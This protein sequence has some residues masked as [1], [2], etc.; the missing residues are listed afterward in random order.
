MILI[1]GLLLRWWWM[2]RL[3]LYVIFGHGNIGD[4]LCNLLSGNRHLNIW[5][6]S[7]RGTVSSIRTTISMKALI[8]AS[9]DERS[10][11]LLCVS[12]RLAN[13]FI[14][15]QILVGKRIESRRRKLN[16]GNLTI[17]RSERRPIRSYYGSINIERRRSLR[18]PD[19]G[20]LC[21]TFRSPCTSTVFSS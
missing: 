7:A 21:A 5:L 17:Y 1:L 9:W 6:I 18:E 11:T 14:G 2:M 8:F 3:G 13:W 4:I 16:K 10:G 15:Q 12:I 20:R 19:K